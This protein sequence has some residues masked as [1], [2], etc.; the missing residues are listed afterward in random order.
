MSYNSIRLARWMDQPQFHNT[1]HQ[2]MR[3]SLVNIFKDV[4]ILPELEIWARLASERPS[5]LNVMGSGLAEW[6]SDKLQ[7]PQYN[8]NKT[9]QRAP[10]LYGARSRLNN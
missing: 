1:I 8:G 5:N 10:F 4:F 9:R 2:S 3:T 7:R 6:P